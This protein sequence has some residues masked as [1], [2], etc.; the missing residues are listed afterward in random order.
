M[1][2]RYVYHTAMKTE[3]RIKDKRGNNALLQ[4]MESLQ[5]NDNVKET[6]ML[7]KQKQNKDPLNQ[8]KL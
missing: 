5:H 4:I 1:G 8:W 6:N 7:E 2:K 3:M